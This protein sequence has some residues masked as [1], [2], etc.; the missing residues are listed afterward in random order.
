MS[1]K[2]NLT[3]IASIR[4]ALRAEFGR[5]QYRITSD[6]EIHNRAPFG[7]AL[8]G[9]VNESSGATLHKLYIGAKV[10]GGTGEDHDTGQ[11]IDIIG[12]DTAVVAWE[13]GVRTR[14]ALSHLRLA[15]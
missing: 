2:D 13:S 11:L 8:Y 5:G 1:P 4:R 7:W 15:D 10:E 3:T 12:A 6:G 9:Y 14:A